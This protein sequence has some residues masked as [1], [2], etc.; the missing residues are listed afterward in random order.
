MMSTHVIKLEEEQKR[1]FINMKILSEMNGKEEKETKQR[2]SE[3]S[4]AK[5]IE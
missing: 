1:K 3:K 2:Y 4:Q 5:V